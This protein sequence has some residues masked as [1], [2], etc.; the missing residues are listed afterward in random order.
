MRKAV[1]SLD[2]DAPGVGKQAMID[3]MHINHPMIPIRTN[4]SRDEIASK[5]KAAQP[6]LFPSS[7]INAPPVVPSQTS[8][9]RRPSMAQTSIKPVIPM[10]PFT[11]CALP[12][13]DPLFLTSLGK[14]ETSKKKRSPSPD[15][16]PALKKD[17]PAK[18]TGSKTKLK[19]ASIGSTVSVCAD[20]PKAKKKK[21]GTIHI[22]HYPD[23]VNLDLS[24]TSCDPQTLSSKKATITTHQ[25]KIE[26]E[27]GLIGGLPGTTDHSDSATL[28]Q[29]YQPTSYVPLVPRPDANVQ[30]GGKIDSNDVDDLII[31]TP[32]NCF[33]S[34]NTI[35]GRDISPISPDTPRSSIVRYGITSSEKKKSGSEVFQEERRRV[36]QVHILLDRV[37]GMEKVM[38][39]MQEK[40]DSMADV[41]AQLENQLKDVEERFNNRLKVLEDSC[42]ELSRSFDKAMEE[43][44]AHDE[45]LTR[46]LTAGKDEEDSDECSAHDDSSCDSETSSTA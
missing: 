20:P 4:A 12:P 2:P 22:V 31:L 11:A 17:I 21:V 1:K 16:K 45:V 42:K 39:S 33:E 5:V 24:S 30:L 19:S 37:D 7:I 28:Q 40:T 26:Q 3:W 25:F 34:E 43:I 44:Q 10:A 27:D 13:S 6:E 41:R 29:N 8:K 23:L 38:Q 9:A 15:I 32:V 18:K 36:E 46:L 35:V 14:N